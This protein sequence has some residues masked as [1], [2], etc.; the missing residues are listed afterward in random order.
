[1]SVRVLS[2]IPTPLTAAIA[3][4]GAMA[5]SAAI[6][7]TPVADAKADQKAD[8]KAGQKADAPGY[9]L[10]GAKPVE[11]ERTGGKIVGIYVPT[12]SRSS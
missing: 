8:Q 6:A 3:A 12:G 7:A 10:F 2:R 1:M 11:F 5:V 9:P 4:L